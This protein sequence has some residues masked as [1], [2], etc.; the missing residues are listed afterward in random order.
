MDRLLST[1]TDSPVT[2]TVTTILNND[3]VFAILV[4]IAFAYGQNAGPKLPKW[5]L[6]LFS[7]DIVRV[8]FLSL[9][10]VVRFES[11]PTVAIIIALVFVYIL[12]YI[13]VESTNEHFG[14][15]I[16]DAREKNKESLRKL[17][18]KAAKS[19]IDLK[20]AA[21]KKGVDVQGNI[22]KLQIDV[23]NNEIFKRLRADIKE[24]MTNVR[25]SDRELDELTL[26]QFQLLHHNTSPKETKLQFNSMH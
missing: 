16:N 5:L 17:K 4:I 6:D 15:M 25:L 7:H 13:Y 21:K 26:K 1:N 9:L 18:N 19:G 22:S 23:N 11:R 8:L 3:Y 20:T 12:Q 10:L 14:D 2:N 24:Q